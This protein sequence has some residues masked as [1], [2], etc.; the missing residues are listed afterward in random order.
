MITSSSLSRSGAGIARIAHYLESAKARGLIAPPDCEAAAQQLI[1][2]FKGHL[3]LLYA[4]NLVPRPT[5][6]Q[7]KD[8]VEQSVSLFI[9]AYGVAGA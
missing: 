2:L 5:A 6:K 8:E 4:L 9:S 3:H 1:S 7:I